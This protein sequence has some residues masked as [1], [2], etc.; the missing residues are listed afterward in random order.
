VS[1]C[2]R[3]TI[4]T[5]RRDGTVTLKPQSGASMQ[6]TAEATGKDCQTC[7]PQRGGR[8]VLTDPLEPR[9]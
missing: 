1:M 8:L 7:Q 4:S 5:T 2:V 6:P 3:T 9:L